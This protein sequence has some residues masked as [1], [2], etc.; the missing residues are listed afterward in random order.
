MKTC[1]GTHYA[2][3]PSVCRGKPSVAGWCRVAGV[4]VRW[5]TPSTRTRRDVC[6]DR[7]SMLSMKVS[8]WSAADHFNHVFMLIV[9]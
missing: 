4:G 5:A 1:S 6:R 9:Q 2:S 8:G 3:S 7:R